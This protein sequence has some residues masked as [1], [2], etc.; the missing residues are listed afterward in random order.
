LNGIEQALTA[1][2]KKISRQM[3]ADRSEPI[4]GKSHKFD[5]NNPMQDRRGGRETWRFAATGGSPL[6]IW[7][8]SVD[9]NLI[10]L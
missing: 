6:P 7:L 3:L 9:A 4:K 8:V 1:K 10:L 5:L 2:E